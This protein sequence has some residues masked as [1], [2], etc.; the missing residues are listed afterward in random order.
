MDET[1]FTI[2]T[3]PDG[4]QVDL[5]KDRIDTFNMDETKIRDFEELAIFLRDSSAELIAGLYAYTW[6]GCLDVQLLWVREGD[7]GRGLG[8]KLLSAAEREASARGCHVAMLATHS[9][10]AP[11]F[12]KKLGYEEIG[13]LAGYPIRHK[14]Y[15]LKKTLAGQR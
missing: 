12:Y 4:R 5:L 15:F 7:R 8:S 10:Q 1:Q 2:D 13:V 3:H 11:D 9:F 6:G 14:K